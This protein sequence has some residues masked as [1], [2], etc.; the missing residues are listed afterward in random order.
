MST[1]IVHIDINPQHLDLNSLALLACT[2]TH[3]IYACMRMHRT[4]RTM[5]ICTK[6]ASLLHIKRI[7]LHMIRCSDEPSACRSLSVWLVIYLILFF[8]P[9]LPPSYYSISGGCAFS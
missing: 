4:S 2:P 7:E 9:E 8:P 6:F 5:S 3:T 1:L